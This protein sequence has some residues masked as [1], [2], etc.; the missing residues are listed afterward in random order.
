MNHMKSA[1]HSTGRMIAGLLG[2]FFALLGGIIAFAIVMEYDPESARFLDEGQ[3]SYGRILSVENGKDETILTIQTD[4]ARARSRPMHGAMAQSFR[5][6]QEV[7]VFYLPSDP[8]RVILRDAMPHVPRDIW[9]FLFPAILWLISAVGL[10]AGP[11]ALYLGTTEA[12]G[13]PAHD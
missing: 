8:E 5:P 9:D 1:S 6:G 2:L 13:E 4:S 7:F 11:E 12:P 10:I 3:S